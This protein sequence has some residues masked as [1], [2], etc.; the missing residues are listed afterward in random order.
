MITIMKASAGSGKTYALAKTYIRLL[1]Q[2]PDPTAYRHI[3]AV[4][5]TNKATDEMKRRILKQLHILAVDTEASPYFKDFVPSV[6]PDAETLGRLAG[7]RLR[8]ILHDYGAFAVSTIDRFFQ[9]TLKAFSREIGQFASYQVE[10]D[11]ESLVAES[12]DRLLDGLSPDSKDLLSWLTDS[13]MYRLESGERFKIDALLGEMAPSLASD[14]FREAVE[15]SGVSAEEMFSKDNLLKVKKVCDS[16]ISSF[17]ER[18]ASSASAVVKVF[19]DEGI[20][21]ENTSYGFMAKVLDYCAIEKGQKIDRPSGAFLGKA[22]DSS[23]WFK[24]SDAARF[25]GAVGVLSP[26]VDDFIAL[27]DTPFR[28]YN[29]ARIIRGQ[30]YSLGLAGALSREFS[31][32]MKEKNVLCL[33][34]SNTILRDIIDGSDAPFVYEKL[35][36]R[37]EDFLLDEFQDTSTI[38]WENFRPLLENSEA[39]GN[40]NLV[41]GDVKQSIYRFRGSDW[42]LLDR[43]LPESFPDERIISLRGNY[44]TLKEIVAFNNRFFPFAARQVSANLG[45]DPDSENSIPST[46]CRDMEQDVRTRDAA[47][48]SVDVVF[49]EKGEDQKDEIVSTISELLDSGARPEDIAVLVRGNREGSEIASR[50]IADSFPVV[51]DDSLQVKSSSV[52][53]LVVSAFALADNPPREDGKIPVA[54]FEAFDSGLEVPESYD[55]LFDLAEKTIAAV[56]KLHPGIMDGEVPYVQSFMDYLQDWVSINGNNLSAFLEKWKD[57][58]LKIASPSG[59]GSVRIM[60]IH[61]S[62]G[63]E[64]P[65]V[66]LPFVEKIELFKSEDRPLFRSLGNWYPVESEGTAFSSTEGLYNVRFTKSSGETL[67]ARSFAREKRLQAI[68]AF[69][70]MYVAMTRPQKGLKVIG[71]VPSKKSLSEGTVSNMSD[72]LY[73]FTGGNYSVGEPYDFTAMKRRKEDIAGIS[74]DYQSFL[75]DEGGRLRISSDASDYFGDDGSTGLSASERIRGIVLHGILSSVKVPSDLPGAVEKAVSD[76]IVPASEKKR[77]LKFLQDEINSVKNRGWFPEDPSRV[78]NEKTLIDADGTVHR[79]DRIVTDG[80]TA[81]VIDYKFGQPRDSYLRQVSR[82]ASILRRIGFTSVE[83]HLW[84]IREEGEDS[85]S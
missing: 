36:V 50:L 40:E 73:A 61:K 4:T 19:S 48:G 60:T 83:A 22:A 33:D 1:L 68:D 80:S 9:Q 58:D 71:E 64:F 5:F 35:G 34:D 82:Y 25:S 2:N 31:A 45:E 66:I 7:D 24:K 55:S 26:V 49:I 15:K 75:P 85:I 27:F 42:R 67:F 54:A 17:E 30:I 37:Y 41:V 63:L 53:R 28:E 43:T 3:L 29:T 72:I 14:R 11:R 21:V 46:I 44:R 20:S 23:K 65:Y 6:C 38:Q 74:L 39:A 62:K 18:V 76:G 8:R 78:L 59:E 79:P 57:V 81:I 51:S 32:L 69:N 56:R 77:I 70:I 52:V 16:V 47:P 84:Y 13:S 10:L 12:V